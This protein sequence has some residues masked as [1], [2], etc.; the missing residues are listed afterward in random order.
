[1]CTCRLADWL[2]FGIESKI[3]PESPLDEVWEL[4]HFVSQF[5]FGVVMNVLRHIAVSGRRSCRQGLPPVVV[6]SSR[7]S[8]VVAA[9]ETL[10]VLYPPRSGIVARDPSR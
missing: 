9:E 3:D 10:V 4:E 2:M 7:E 5:I 1:M 8:Q 6:R